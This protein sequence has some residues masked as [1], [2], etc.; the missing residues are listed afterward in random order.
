MGVVNK[1]GVLDPTKEGG[2]VAIYYTG[3][4]IGGF[5][6]GQVADKYGRIKAMIVGCLWTIVGG[7]LMV[8]RHPLQP[9]YTSHCLADSLSHRPLP[10]I[11]PG[12]VALVLLLV[13]ESASS[14]QSFRRYD[15]PF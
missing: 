3:G 5:W 10:K 8:G 2:I 15:K 1:M 11:S 7:S 13:L 14:S 12:C 9:T 6:G 4:I